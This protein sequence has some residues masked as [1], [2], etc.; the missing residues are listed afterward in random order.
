MKKL[1]AFSPLIITVFAIVAFSVAFSLGVFDETT[2]SDLTTYT[3]T[4]IV[5]TSN[6][7]TAKYIQNG[8]VS[9]Q[10][11]GKQGKILYYAYVKPTIDFSEIEEISKINNIINRIS[12]NKNNWIVNELKNN[13]NNKYETNIPNIHLMASKI[14]TK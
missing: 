14:V 13:M 8:I 10:K 12:E 1:F 7:S 4:E 3:L 9:Y 11:E 6:L 2:K 5:N